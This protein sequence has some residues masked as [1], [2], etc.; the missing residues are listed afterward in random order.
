MT[1][2]Q[3]IGYIITASF[4]LAVI[5]QFQPHVFYYLKTNMLIEPW[6]FYSAHF[7]HVG[8]VHL[9][10]NMLALFCLPYIFKQINPK[11]FLSALITLPLFL[12]LI[13]Y[14]VYP[15]LMVYAGFSGVLHGLYALAGIY[16]LAHP[17]E[18][19]FGYLILVALAIKLI[20]EGVVD[21][22]LGT[23][24]LIGSPV[25]IEA[26]LWGVIGGVLLWAMGHLFIKLTK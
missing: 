14:W 25:M 20:W 1:A 15:H 7:V 19:K 17:L 18:R 12:S 3:S 8:W 4:M 26:H 6:R 5:F 24:D 2:Q 10:L 11:W 13:F 16:A 22:S 23:A 9:G 21:H